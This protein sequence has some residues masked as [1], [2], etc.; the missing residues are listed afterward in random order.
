MWESRP[1]SCL[2]MPFFNKCPVSDV[3][4]S[5]MIVQGFVRRQWRCGGDGTRADCLADRYCGARL[6]NKDPDQTG[7]YWKKKKINQQITC[8]TSGEFSSDFWETQ[9]AVRCANQD[10][11]SGARWLLPAP[12]SQESALAQQFCFVTPQL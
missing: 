9:R 8:T 12:M 7:Y 2:V 3:R 4:E 1:R 5:A 6:G 10:R 11:P